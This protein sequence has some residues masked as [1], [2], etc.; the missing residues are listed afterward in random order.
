MTTQIWLI[1]LIGFSPDI[2]EEMNI[3]Q[4]SLS[5]S[6]RVIALFTLIFAS[7][8]SRFPLINQEP[9]IFHGECYVAAVASS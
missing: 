5:I 6:H 1:G 8:S 7:N 2:V 9:K 4:V 3:L